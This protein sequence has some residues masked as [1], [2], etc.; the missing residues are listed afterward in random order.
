MN[1]QALMRQAQ[2]LQQEMAKTKSEIEG[3]VYLGQSSVVK[4]EVNGKR[5]V[6][7][8]EIDREFDFEVSNVEILEDMIALAINDALKKVELE[9]NEKL[10]KHAPGLSGLI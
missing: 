10:G 8:V 1:M 2:K 9:Y 4:V 3:K 7:K 5:E 6:Q